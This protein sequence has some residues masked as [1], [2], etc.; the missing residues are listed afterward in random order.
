MLR[1]TSGNRRIRKRNYI[2]KNNY[3]LE[4]A[5]I[6]TIDESEINIRRMTRFD[7][8]MILELDRKIGEGQS[9]VSYR[10]LVITDPTGPLDFSFVPIKQGNETLNHFSL[11][12]LLCFRSITLQNKN[13]KQG[14]I[15]F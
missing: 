14:N 12:I 1:G 2:L 10:D 8:N 9:K 11:I 13:R 4:V 5:K 15:D 3:D 7:I 6:R